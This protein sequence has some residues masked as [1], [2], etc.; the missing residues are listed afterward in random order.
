MASFFVSRVDAKADPQLGAGSPLRGQ[1]AI[2]N[3]HLA[4]GRYL[5]RFSGERWEALEGVGARRQR[6]LWASTGTKDPAY[7]D[8]LYVERLIAPGVINTM[9]EK[10][11]QAFAD[12]GDVGRALEADLAGAERVLE[13]AADAGLDLAALTTELEREG[14]QSFCD[15][16]EELLRCIESRLAALPA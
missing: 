15:S 9:P 13:Q 3:A 11:L 8:V 12:H 5:A 1:V 2:A 14:V 4:Y 6:P 7:S 10:T 16:Y